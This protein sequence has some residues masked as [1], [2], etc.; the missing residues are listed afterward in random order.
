VTPSGEK[1]ARRATINPKPPV[2]APT[3]VGRLD[4]QFAYRRDS[5][6]DEYRTVAPALKVIV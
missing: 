2:P 6:I 1:T 3:I 4:R 5:D